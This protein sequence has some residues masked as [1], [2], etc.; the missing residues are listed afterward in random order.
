[1][2]PVSDSIC[3]VE[4]SAII[5]MDLRKSLENLGYEVIGPAS[6]ADTA[7]RLVE[8][9]SPDLV[10]MDIMLKGATDGIAAAQ[11]IKNEY[12]IPVIFASAYTDEETLRRAKVTEPFGFV[13]KPFQEKELRSNIE[14]ALYKSRLDKKI[15][16]REKKF[17]LLYE[18]APLGYQSLDAQGRITEVNDAWCAITGYSR[19]KILGTQ[20]SSLLTAESRKRF[21]G[22]F[23]D[24]KAHGT[25]SDTDLQMVHTS[26]RTIIAEFHG[27]VMYAADGSVEQTHC[28]CNDVTKQRHAQR[29]LQNKEYAFEA[30]FNDFPLTTLLVDKDRRIHHI[31]ELGLQLTGNTKT[32]VTGLRAGEALRCIHHLDDPRGCGF[33]EACK[34]C[35]IRKTALDTLNNDRRHQL[36]EASLSVHTSKTTETYY[37][38]VST[39]RLHIE[40]KWFV[41]MGLLD[42]TDRKKNELRLEKAKKEAE[43]LNSAMIET[44]ENEKKLSGQLSQA[45]QEAETANEAKSRFLAN[46]SHEIRTPLNGITGFLSIMEKTGLNTEQK[47]YLDHIRTCASSLKTLIGDILDLT[48][49]ESGKMQLEHTSFDLRHTINKCTEMLRPQA[50][51]KNL[52]CAVTVDSAIPTFL[53]G[54]PG[55]V[56]QIY[57]NLLSNAIKFTHEGFVSITVSLQ[58]R[59][60]N[61][62]VIYSEVTDTGIGIPEQKQEELFDSFSQVDA[63]TTKHYG[64]TGLGLSIVKKLVHMM[65]GRTG[66]HSKPDKGSTFWFTLSTVAAA[67]KTEAVPDS[68]KDNRTLHGVTGIVAGD[69]RDLRTHCVHLLSQLE[70]T[71]VSFDM[72]SSALMYVKNHLSDHTKPCILVVTENLQ[73]ALNFA[74][75]ALLHYPTLTLLFITPRGVPGDAA[76]CKRHGYCAYL[77]GYIPRD[78][79]H[80]TIALTLAPSKE[81]DTYENQVITTHSIEETRHH[82][83]VLVVEDSVMN[84]TMVAIMLKKAG[85]RCD[86]AQNGQQALEACSSRRYDA[87]IMD[88]QMPVMDGYT[89]TRRIRVKEKEE[90]GAHVPII[91]L[92]ANA[93]EQ[94]KDACIK[95]GM[96]DYLAKPI[97]QSQL[98]GKLSYWIPD[99]HPPT[100]DKTKNGTVKPQSNKTGKQFPSVADLCTLHGIEEKE[101]HHLLQQFYLQLQRVL[102]ELDNAIS[103]SRAEDGMQYAHNL[104]GSA[105]NIGIRPIADSATTLEQNLRES[106]FEQARKNCT[107]LKEM[108]T[109]FE[110]EYRVYLK[111]STHTNPASEG[112]DYTPISQQ[113]DNNTFD[114]LMHAWKI[115]DMDAIIDMCDGYKPGNNECGSRYMAHIAELARNF[116]ETELETELNNIISYFSTVKEH[117]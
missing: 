16:E 68:E 86:S 84:Q 83:R 51:E 37:F 31:N 116:N 54:D 87:V 14:L 77:T 56:K 71:A 48:K 97:D 94:D 57:L 72:L 100:A 110:Q 25:I 95:A 22:I 17:R 34:E 78:I 61:E 18:N 50:E 53:Y 10:L 101:M 117:D 39:A 89:A 41:L 105:G 85:I 11:R 7:L 69:H 8:T 55:R 64:G 79:L 28:I 3:I 113:I 44:L 19:Q 20:F 45:R 52:E 92:T 80:D 24:F 4:D 75:H 1:M 9:H 104:K 35:T 66:V 63:S 29:E 40:D 76:R 46:M 2:Q 82:T 74:D 73:K 21:P 33:S 108:C 91:A 49:I 65:G 15:Y 38:L 90:G 43:E 103:D 12:H 47:N 81:T 23:K 32:N 107:R 99:Y 96:D 70:I 6:D 5:A 26:G 67:E 115:G 93:L 36:V 30:I 42:I 62:L 27:R 58:K 112:F 88:C 13:V 114:A 60:A 111:D 106:R 59:N 102:T 98:I 109:H